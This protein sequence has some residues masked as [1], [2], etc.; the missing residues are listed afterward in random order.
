MNVMK[1]RVIA[2][3]LL[4]GC[5]VFSACG[6]GQNTEGQNASEENI[7]TEGS[8]TLEENIAEDV[9]DTAGENASLDKNIN[10]E[11]NSADMNAGAGMTTSYEKYNGFWSEDGKNNEEILTDGGTE[12]YVQ[13]IDGDNLQGYLYSQQGQSERIAEI[14]NIR[15]KIVDG[16]ASYAFSDDGFGDRGTLQILFEENQIT[17]T[18]FNF[19]MGEDNASGFGI[20]GSYTFVPMRERGSFRT[21]QASGTEQPTEEV[22]YNGETLKR[23]REDWEEDQI[24]EEL[25][26]R[27][28]Y[29]NQCS[30]YTDYV[31]F[32]E[33]EMGI[34]DISVDMYPQYNTNQ[35][36]YEASDFSNATPLIIYL[37][38]NE[39]YARHGYIFK[40]SD[41]ENFFLSQIWYLPEVDADDFDSS[42][43][44]EYEV[45]NLK[46]L[47]ELDTYNH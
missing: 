47:S 38:K 21:E 8:S 41:L 46:M 20:S 17:I 1:K 15:C 2:V 32:M 19:K 35:K 7:M 24:M 25:N 29:R 22:E 23:F 27:V 45:E 40:D 31:R 11:G 4:A 13:I 6:T 44:N 33:N 16:A 43:L 18:V 9:S 39:I 42:V 28:K 14:E 10:S 5:I 34:T 30:F 26:K 37:A 36:Y 3:I 12:F